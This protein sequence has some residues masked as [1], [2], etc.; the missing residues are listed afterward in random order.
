VDLC[1]QSIVFDSAADVAACLR[2]IREDPDAL[3]VRVKN[4][5][6][7]AYDAAASA[8]YR[9]VVLNMR[10][11]CA[12]TVGLGVDGHVCEVQLI[13]RLFAEHK[14]PPAPPADPPHLHCWSFCT[15]WHHSA[16]QAS[17]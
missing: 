17:F 9:D 11:C 10:L 7:P 15:C 3:V 8:G 6:D 5:L 1:R 12:E 2:A 14:V 13:H 4:R 16:R